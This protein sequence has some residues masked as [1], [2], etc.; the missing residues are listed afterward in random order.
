[1]PKLWKTTHICL[2]GF[3]ALIRKF[4]RCMDIEEYSKSVMETGYF[5]T[6]EF[7]NIAFILREKNM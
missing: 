4:F 2:K 1:M 6:L 3:D 7:R 5:A